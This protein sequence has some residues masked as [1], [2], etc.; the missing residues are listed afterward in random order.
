MLGTL[1]SLGSKYSKYS[2]YTPKGLI[3]QHVW[4]IPKA[5]ITIPNKDYQKAGGFMQGSRDLPVHPNVSPFGICY[6]FLLR[7]D[8]LGPRDFK[9][10]L[11]RA[12]GTQGVLWI[13]TRE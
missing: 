1:K 4:C 5:I 9:G 6:A 7:D 12:G 3:T 2:V 10:S 13:N 11:K 8:G